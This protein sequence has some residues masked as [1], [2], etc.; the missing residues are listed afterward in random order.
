[1]I[2]VQRFAALCAGAA[3]LG[4][5]A[6]ARAL[7]TEATVAL[8]GAGATF[9]AP[10]YERWL[11]DFK[12]VA[13]AI[14]VRYEAVGSGEG[15][16][17]FLAGTVDFGAS[18]AALTDAELARADQQRGVA[19]V[20]MTAGMVVLAYNIPDLRG[21]LTLARDVYADIFA[22]KISHWDDPRITATNPGLD[23]PH[24]SIMPVVRRDSSGTTFLFTKHLGAVSPA[25]SDTGPG[26]GK[27]VDWP[28]AAMAVSGNAGVAARVKITDGAVGYM[29][30]EFA[31]RLGLPIARLQNRAG[32]T[33]DASPAAGRAAL[34]SAAEI[35]ADLRVFVPDPAGAD[36]WPITG[37]SWV[38][39]YQRYP[40]PAKAE[41]VKALFGWALDEGQTV[42]RDL[43]YVPLPAAMVARA[44]EVLA[45]V[46]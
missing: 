19:M 2:L 33:V 6:S 41:A 40:D 37:Y 9:P 36:A 1:M 5:L 44:R 25:W 23:L 28:G 38:L 32:T 20:P 12:S 4:V 22:G 17:R 27:L 13:P 29:E 46:R 31:E 34:A 45:G 24:K 11:V 18:D 16:A 7:T 39:L 21:G 42:A 26:V 15:V 35:P 10:L 43:G 30:Y 14:N 3:L 8:T